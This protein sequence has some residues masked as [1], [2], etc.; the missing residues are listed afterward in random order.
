MN[1]NTGKDIQEESIINI[2]VKNIIA[3]IRQLY[4]NLTEL[5]N[6]LYPILEDEEKK[7]KCVEEAK[8]SDPSKLDGKLFDIE[9]DINRIS[10]RIMELNRSLMIDRFDG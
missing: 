3:G 5:E 9:R 2:R 10:S 7:D 4:S 6:K 1:E 8:E